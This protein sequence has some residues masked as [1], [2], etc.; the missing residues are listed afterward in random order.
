MLKGKSD[1]FLLA[2]FDEHLTLNECFKMHNF[3]GYKRFT[4]SHYAVDVT[5]DIDGFLIKNIE[6]TNENIIKAIE[7]SKISFIQSKVHQSEP[8][9][10]RKSVFSSITQKIQ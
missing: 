4:V 10:E 9:D 5:Y 7:T 2:K 1:Q 8:V 3:D 6:Q